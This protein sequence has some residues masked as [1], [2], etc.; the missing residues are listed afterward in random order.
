M[1]IEKAGRPVG[2]PVRCLVG[3]PGRLQQAHPE[4][5][6]DGQ[7]GGHAGE[8]GL[9]IGQ[10]G[11]ALGQPLDVVGEQAHQPDEGLA[12][13]VVAQVQGDEGGVGLQRRLDAR[14]VDAV[15]RLDRAARGGDGADLG[16]APAEPPAAGSPSDATAYPAAAPTA[17]P[18]TPRPSA[19]SS[20][21]RVTP[22]GGCSG[23]W[24]GTIR[25]GQLSDGLGDMDSIEPS[26]GT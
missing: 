19:P 17:S 4:A 2:Q 12:V 22:A 24:S 26:A 1:S 5:D 21:R 8:L 18:P 10:R 11:A 3:Q 6:R 23:C 14:L 15:E 7:P 20:P 25:G 13:D 9:R 16:A